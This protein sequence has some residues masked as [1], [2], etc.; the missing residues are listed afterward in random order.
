[1]L[2]LVN[3]P[4]SPTESLNAFAASVTWIQAILTGSIATAIGVIAIA[5]IGLLMLSGRLDLRG[6]GRVILGCF[7]VYGSAVLAGGLLG[8]TR[9]DPQTRAAKPPYTPVAVPEQL[10]SPAQRPTSDPYAGAAVRR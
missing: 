6:G 5:S 8:A 1:M 10:L 9:L 3:S 7:V 2:P 4:Q